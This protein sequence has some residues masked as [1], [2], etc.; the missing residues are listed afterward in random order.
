MPS[1]PDTVRWKLVPYVLLAYGAPA[2]AALFPQ[3][4][5]AGFLVV[6]FLLQLTAH[7]VVFGYYRERRTLTIQDAT[8]T[9]QG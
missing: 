1:C 7:A 4:A 9:E 3:V 8:E 6:C 2:A 5:R